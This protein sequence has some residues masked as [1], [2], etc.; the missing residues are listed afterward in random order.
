MI[1]R[2][3]SSSAL[4][5]TLLTMLPGCS[6]APAYRQPALPV[7]ASW[8]AGDAYLKQQEAALPA[9][10]YREV[11]ADPRL[12]AVI[13]QALANNQDV[14]RAAAN[15]AAARAQYQVQRAELLPQLDLGASYRRSDSGANAGA[16]SFALQGSVSGYEVDLFGRLRSL[17]D[18]AQN[19]YFASEAAAR[20]TR[21]TLVADVADAWLA[22]AA[23]STLLALA[24]QTATA[25][26]ESV[27]LTQR[28]LDGGVAPRSDL[29]Q[30]QI[31]LAT[32]EADIAAQT[33]AVAQDRNALDLLVGAPVDA[34]QLSGTITDAVASLKGIPAGLDSTILL[35]RPDVIEAEWQLQAANAQIGAARAALF[36]RISLTSVLGFASSALGGLFSGGNFAWST[37][38]GASYPIFSGGAGKAGVALSE[39]Q[40][41]A[42]LADYRKAIQTAFADVADTLARRGTIEPQLHAVTAGRDAAAD[43]AHLAELRYRGGVSSYLESLTAQLSLYA[44]QRNLT[45]TQRLR[46]SNLVALY[47]SLGGDPLPQE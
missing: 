29:R 17:G 42:A 15:I 11:L 44:A 39:A 10:S 2:L 41:D 9:Y 23:D 1:R 13:D 20:A 32:A 31:V 40:R 22:Y 24:R 5:L 14:R 46:A 35:R 16:G 36:P 18:A 33:N 30:A 21:L 34:A 3:R 47:R 27:R 43:N 45:N 26:R 7:P 38:G 8:P 12:I 4:G 25:A 6:M 37:T 28:R 19:R